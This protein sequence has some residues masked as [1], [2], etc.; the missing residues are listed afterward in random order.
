MPSVGSTVVTCIVVLESL[1]PLDVVDVVVASLV[2][3]S[4]ACV[5][6]SVVVPLAESEAPPVVV[7]WVALSLAPDA[8]ISVVAAVAD[9]DDVSLS[10]ALSEPSLDE[11]PLQPRSATR[12][13]E[14]RSVNVLRVM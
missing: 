2:I 7:P 10:L 8:D 5:V 4:L 14:G 1:S 12:G 6:A 11:P 3:E 13:I 9:D